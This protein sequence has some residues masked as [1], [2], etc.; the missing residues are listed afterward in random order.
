MR[1]PLS[2]GSVLRTA[3][4]LGCWLA[5]ALTVAQ[6]AASQQATQPTTLF[7]NAKIFDGTSDQLKSGA[8]LVEGNLIKAVGTD[9]ENPPGANVIDCGS[10]T[11]M[12]GLI[13]GHAHIAIN[14]NYP[15]IEANFTAGD[16]HVRATVAA[17]RCLD[18]GFTTVRDLGGPVFGLKRA[19]DRDLL[20][21]PRIYPCGAFISQ[22]SGHGD[23]RHQ[24]DPNPSLG[25][26]L[27]A[28]DS[29]NFSRFGIGIVA[30]GRPAVLAAVRQNLMMEA[31]QIKIM[32]GGG[33]SSK[34]DP[35][36]VAQYTADEMKAAVEAAS[37]WD[38]Y[39]AGHLFTD[40]SCQRFIEAGGKSIEHGFFMSED[41]I[42]LCGERE[43]FVV[44]QCWG[45][46][47]ELFKNPNVPASKHEGIRK[48][49]ADSKDFGKWLLKHNV[50]VVFASDL[51]GELEDGIRWRRYEL[52]WR[53]KV[54]GNN[55]EVL[56]QLTSTAGELMALSGKRNP[57]Q[58]KLGVIEA[59]ALADIIVVDGNP[60]ED[61]TVLGAETSVF[62][63]PTPTEIHTIRLIMK[64]GGIY[65]NTLN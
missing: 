4:L 49:Q 47:P 34:Y 21:G 53:T 44:P 35:I 32:A 7:T 48:L 58:G 65:K 57:Y 59:G 9:I 54:F 5:T 63:A 6:D 22:S 13:D 42:K 3:A 60:L 19:I 25:G 27:G 23:F 55:Y 31:T 62:D 15:D 61:M 11:L 52:H 1:N 28:A 26:R 30:D 43:V 56:K 64:D 29:S 18:D 39:V 36:D 12:P 10:R 40:K 50:K 37:D 24:N 38:T 16:V 51:V 46:S 2:S 41:T 33:G 45:I 8:V 17:R 20:P 14:A